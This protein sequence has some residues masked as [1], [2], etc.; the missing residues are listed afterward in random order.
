MILLRDRAD[1]RWLPGRHRFALFRLVSYFVL[2]AV[3]RQD[4]RGIA[5]A[6]DP[7]QSTMESYSVAA[8][9]M[10][11]L[12]C[13]AFVPLQSVM[14]AAIA[15]VLAVIAASAFLHMSVL[16]AIVLPARWRHENHIGLNS[17]MTMLFVTAFAAYF[18]S[19]PTWIRYVALAF[20]ATVALNAI[21]AAVA[22]LMRE[23]LEAADAEMRPV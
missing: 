21:A 3:G 17:F 14:P 13:F 10:I 6:I 4:K 19:W 12:T 5:L 2:R 20:L 18:A 23:R 15:A 16:W 8:W 22:W 1:A 11:V 7:D 9:L